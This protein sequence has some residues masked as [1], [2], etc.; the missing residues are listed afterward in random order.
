VRIA[1][2]SPY[3]PDEPGVVQDH[4]R[5][6][7]GWL[8]GQGH[9]V[10]I[11][12]P[13][14]D[15]AILR[16]GRRRL[17]ALAAGDPDALTGTPGQPLT[18]ALGPALP[19][20]GRAAIAVPAAAAA[21]AGLLAARAGLDI[22]HVHEPGLPVTP[23][24]RARQGRAVCVA[25]FHTALPAALG[26][27]RSRDRRFGFAD[28]L[29][30]GSPAVLEALAA[31]DGERDWHLIPTGVDLADERPQ[32]LVP[33]RVIVETTAG[34]RSAVRAVARALAPLRAEVV[35]VSARA[36]PRPLAGTRSARAGTPLARGLLL[37]GAAVFVAARDGSPRLALEALAAGVA[38]AAPDDSPAASLISPDASGLTFAANAPELASAVALRL[39]EDTELRTTLARAG[40]EIA[41]AQAF[42]RVA[43]QLEELYGELLARRRPL[44]D[45]TPE[46]THVRGAPVLADL[47][48]HTHHSG[49]CATPVDD[50]LDEAVERGLAVIAVTDH[51]TIA[52][53]LEAAQR[54]QER[55]LDLQVIVGSEI[56]T[57]GQGEVIGL[58]LREEVPKG[59]TFGETVSRIHAQGGLVYIPH[60]FDRMHSIPS[61]EVLRRHVDQIDVLE[62]ANG[63]LYFEKD[64]AES[65]RFAERWNLLR[66]AGSDAHVSEGLATAVLRLPPFRGPDGLLASLR[67]AEIERRPRN[68]LYLQG[69]KWVRQLG[70][71]GHADG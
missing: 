54:V 6:V 42:P 58:F 10:V 12:A 52:G 24:R 56:M 68:L 2:V 37:R 19:L 60:P 23:Y 3:D 34:N 57:D 51:N 55:S 67:T 15:R 29:V 25:S 16:E 14:A 32:P 11:A 40:R 21:G 47:H 36:R 43:A 65:E 48:M 1:H 31:H 35:L 13:S 22:V 62:T 4:V 39:L 46:E 53:G 9:E 8:A 69:L 27:A 41:A 30:A 5:A 50:L 44:A 64:N 66:G 63:R 26:P 7:T 20:R 49:D 71:S 70:R 18:L 33:L 61:P 45:D 28:A 59:L 38:I 17:A